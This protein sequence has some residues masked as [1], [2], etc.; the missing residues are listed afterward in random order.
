MS[1]AHSALQM[2]TL[3]PDDLQSLVVEA[4]TLREQLPADTKS[5][6][7]HAVS[8]AA[9]ASSAD[10]GAQ[11]PIVG[12]AAR[13]LTGETSS[14]PAGSSAPATADATGANGTAGNRGP[15]AS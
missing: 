8:S 6:S 5:L 14:Q 13:A 7:L 2:A 3:S 15:F 12:S 11:P 1:T 4:T 10:S 9:P